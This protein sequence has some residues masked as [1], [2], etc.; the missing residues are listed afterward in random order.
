[1]DNWR[2]RSS[3]ELAR[4]QVSPF[5]PGAPTCKHDGGHGHEAMEIDGGVKWN[6]SVEEGLPAQRDDVATH[7][8]EHVGEQEGDGSSGA[9]GEGH[10]H[11]RRLR[12]A[13]RLSLETV[14]W[15]GT[16]GASGKPQTGRG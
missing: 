4:P 6:V 14:V 12:E 5:V 15:N 8:E 1:M 13:C 2:R 11:H 10:A 3:R 16:G 7:G 9:A